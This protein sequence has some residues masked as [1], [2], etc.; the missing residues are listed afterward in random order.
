MKA[1]TLMLVLVALFAAGLDASERDALQSL[2]DALGGDQWERND[3]WGSAAPLGEWHGVGTHNGRVLEIDLAGNGLTG[4]L[5]DGLEDLRH[6]KALDL[7]WNTI[8]GAIPDSIGELANLE[9]VLLSGNELTGDIPRSFG[10][11]PA[12]KRLDLSYNR[13]SGEIP[14]TLGQSRSL[15]AL[16][17]QHNQLTGSLP[18]E[19][20]R[21][22]TLRRLIAHGNHLASAV[23]PELE[24]MPALAHLKIVDNARRPSE[25]SG[26]DLLD[27]TTMIIDEEVRGLM[28]QVM[29]AI[30]AR[31]GTL[32]L[33]TEAVP[34]PFM[35]EQLQAAVD[36]MNERLRATGRRIES[37]NDLD[38]ELELY[39]GGPT[40]ELNLPE[41]PGGSVFTGPSS[42]FWSDP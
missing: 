35:E 16:G 8:G 41:A 33:D 4:A 2:Y 13:L 18:S 27:E 34:H 40:I 32:H 7:R 31:D 29:A 37:V 3:G 26:L 6:L 42:R 17:L 9:S 24:Q 36:G 25:I 20:R 12:L 30:V 28:G 39:D 1:H 21:I 22:G 14:A 23:P 19:L 10:S 11:M 15:Q 5:P 38:R